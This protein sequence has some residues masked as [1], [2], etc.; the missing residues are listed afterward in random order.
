MYKIWALIKGTP[1][2]TMVLWILSSLMLIRIWP[3]SKVFP[4][5]IELITSLS[6]THTLVIIKDRK[7][8]SEG[9]NFIKHVKLFPIPPWYLW[10]HDACIH[11][12]PHSWKLQN[13]K[14]G[15]ILFGE[16]IMNPWL[17]DW[18]NLLAQCLIQSHIWNYLND[19][20][21]M[22]QRTSQILH[23]YLYFLYI[24]QNIYLDETVFCLYIQKHIILQMQL[25]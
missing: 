7:D 16:R 23:I 19:Y 18:G 1:T 25:S 3:F 8:F 24:C 13:L 6:I 4:R 15:G 2:C 21:T 9:S 12:L 11:T 20:H 5:F 14:Q 10:N 22:H 17:R